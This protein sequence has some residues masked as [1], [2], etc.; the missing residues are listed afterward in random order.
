MWYNIP[1]ASYF[2]E[3]VRIIKG[4]QKVRVHFICPHL[5]FFLKKHLKKTVFWSFVY[6]FRK[7]FLKITK[8]P[9]FVI[10]VV[11]PVLR[12]KKVFF[13]KV[14]DK[15]SFRLDLGAPVRAEKTQMDGFKKGVQQKIF[16]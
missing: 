11:C 7:A 2:C 6:D 12:K 8:T 3:Q 14:F 4:V 1:N 16:G 13:K 15:K 9:G 5:R 10:I